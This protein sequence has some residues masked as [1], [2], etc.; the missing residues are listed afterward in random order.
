VASGEPEE[1]ESRGQNGKEEVGEMERMKEAI[2]IINQ[3][4]QLLI[5][6]NKE[7]IETEPEQVRKNIE[8]ILQA[9]K[10]IHEFNH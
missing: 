7:H 4:I 1:R 5:D 9:L 8:T 2:L 10:I 3:Q 6:W